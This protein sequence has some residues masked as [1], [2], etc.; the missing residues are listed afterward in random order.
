MREGE[1]MG[2]EGSV[3]EGMAGSGEGR[4]EERGLKGAEGEGDWMEMAGEVKGVNTLTY[5]VFFQFL[6]YLTLLSIITDCYF[7]WEGREGSGNGGD[8]RG[9][10]GTGDEGRTGDR[11]GG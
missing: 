7:E 10:E 11:S 1:A 2:G 8:E 3:G 5:L 4:G 9:W 6:K